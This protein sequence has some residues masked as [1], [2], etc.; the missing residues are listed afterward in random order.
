MGL[1]GRAGGLRACV[2]PCGGFLVL[3]LAAGC[4]LA[5]LPLGRMGLR[6]P[7]LVLRG[8]PC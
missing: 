8:R 3:G 4:A 5:G 1:R 7:G 6:S 2:M